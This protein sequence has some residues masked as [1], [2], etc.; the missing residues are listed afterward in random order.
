MAGA[1]N[2]PTAAGEAGVGQRQQKSN[3]SFETAKLTSDLQLETADEGDEDDDGEADDDACGQKGRSNFNSKWEKRQ[4]LSPESDSSPL[5]G[6]RRG[7]PRLGCTTRL[8]RLRKGTFSR[9]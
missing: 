2:K 4:S 8:V 5:A 7:C 1:G 9:L 3:K 6:C